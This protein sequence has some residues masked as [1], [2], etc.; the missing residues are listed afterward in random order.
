MLYFPANQLLG[1][2]SEKNYE[3]NSSKMSVTYAN[4]K[5]MSPKMEEGERMVVESD[6][7]ECKSMCVCVTWPILRFSLL[8]KGYG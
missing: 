7:E 1:S 5:I 3:W 8:A 6:S 2:S 4:P